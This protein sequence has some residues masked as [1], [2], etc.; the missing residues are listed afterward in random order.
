M[1]AKSTSSKH[2]R[3]KFEAFKLSKLLEYQKK[4]KINELKNFAKFL[5]KV[6]VTILHRNK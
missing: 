4:E 5:A 2:L 1:N 3:K 6:F